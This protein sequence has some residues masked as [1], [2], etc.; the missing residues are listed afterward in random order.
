MNKLS[1]EQRAKIVACLV[2]GNS[3]RA[4]CRMTGAAK[5]TVTK[6][7]VDLGWACSAYQDRTLVDLP[8][9]RMQIDELWAFVYARSKNLPADKQ[10][11]A[12]FGSVWTWVALDPDSKLVPTWRV[13]P[14]DATEGTLLLQDL[15]RRVPQRIQITTD[16]WGSYAESVEAEYGTDV[17]YAQVVK[18]YVAP[19][20]EGRRGAFR[21]VEIWVV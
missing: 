12:G 1:T 6:L 21:E 10:D 14:H 5:G 18:H 20:R 9:E 4:T 8:C 16:G 2:E 19:D 13:G 15:R 11:T 17:D 7:L 3:I